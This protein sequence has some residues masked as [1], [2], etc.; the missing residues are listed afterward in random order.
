MHQALRLLLRRLP[1]LSASFEHNKLTLHST[2]CLQKGQHCLHAATPR[3]VRFLIP[4]A[5]RPSQWETAED[6]VLSYVQPHCRLKT[7]TFTC[8]NRTKYLHQV[9]KSNYTLN[10]FF[11]AVCFTVICCTMKMPEVIFPGIKL[12]VPYRHALDILINYCHLHFLHYLQRL[13]HEFDGI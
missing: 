4:S 12:T 1:R 9:V 3:A 2:N 6:S 10:F 5:P 11:V 13:S 8:R 7:S